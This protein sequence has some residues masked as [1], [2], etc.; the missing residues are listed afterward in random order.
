M[1]ITDL[2]LNAVPVVKAGMLIRKPAP[3][4]YEA[5]IDPAITSQFWFSKG[6]ARLDA[7]QPVRWDW[8]WY[9]VSATV[10]VVALDPNR[11]ISI[12]W[13]GQNGQATVE[14]RFTP[15]QNDTTYV[16]ITNMGFTGDGDQVVAEALD[17]MG[18]F[19][20]LLAGCKAFL[21]HGIRLNLVPDHVPP[22]M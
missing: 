7:D 17:S 20:F 12:E 18:G 1:E 14:W 15:M 8:E 6:S 22:G 10:R 5:F 4:V 9:G 11:Y 21:E 19:S 2:H 3:E 13:P 16:Q